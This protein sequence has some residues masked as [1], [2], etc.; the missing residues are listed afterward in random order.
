MGKVRRAI[1]SLLAEIEAGN[2]TDQDAAILEQGLLGTVAGMPDAMN[3]QRTQ[4]SGT[5]PTYLKARDLIGERGRGIDYG[6]GL[7]LGAQAL[8][9]DDYEPFPRAGYSPKYRDPRQIPSNSY[10]RLTNLNV[11]NVVPREIRD[12]IV[13]DMGRVMRPDGVGVITTRGRDVLN[14]KNPRLGP[15]PM[16]V[17]T[18]KDTYQKGFTQSELRDYLRYILGDNFDVES[19]KLGPAGAR[20]RKKR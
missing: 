12:Q 11:L 8:D 13:S 4:I 18:S 20:I 16:S 5:L 14:A 17:I 2:L 9:L 6:A 1:K 7:G 3:A 19:V 15:E 10:D